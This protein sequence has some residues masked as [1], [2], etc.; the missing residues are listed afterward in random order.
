MSAPLP[1]RTPEL[2]RELPLV[3]RRAD[4]E[5]LHRLFGHESRVQPMVLVTGE[6]GVGKSRVT[7]AVEQE[8]RHRG[9]T[10]ASGRAY[11]VET[12][13]PYSL[14]S[15]AFLPILRSYDDATLTVLTRGTSGDL[16]QLFPAL[17]S[18]DDTLEDWDPAESKTRLF[19]SFTEFV[20]R[21]AERT[22]VLIVAEDLH[23]ADASSLSLLHFVARQ[24]QGEPIRVLATVSSG[25]GKD[26]ESLRGFERSLS[27]LDLLARH[28]LPPLSLDAVEELLAAVFQVGG[29]PLHEFAAPLY[30]WTHGNPYFL[31]ETLKTL[32]RTG[33]LHHRDGTWLGWEARNLDLP[34][35][36]RDALLLRL[37]S[38]SHAARAVADLVAVSGG[39]A[40]VRLLSHVGDLAQEALMNAVEEL[41]TQAVVV[42]REE[43]RDVVL[44]LRHPMLRETVYR[45]LGPS[46]RQLLH[47]RL[48][49]GL[50]ALH[51]AADAPVDQLAYHFTRAGASG[52][53]ARA[54]RYLAEAGRSALRRHADQEAVAYLETALEWY[55]EA[56]EAAPGAGRAELPGRGA[57]Q[58][59]LARGLARLGRYADGAVLWEHLLAVARRDEDAEGSAEALHHLGLLAYWSARQE[60]SLAYY[61]RALEAIAERGLQALEARILLAAGVAL[62]ELG[63]AQEARGRIEASLELARSLAD[64]TLLGR[65]HRALALLFTWIGE[66]EAARRHGWQAVEIADRAG[67]AYV[68]FWG[69]WALAS[70]EG[71]TGNTPEMTRLTTQASQVADEL[72]SPVLRLWTAELEI[73]YLLAVGDW[74]GA[75]ALGE[76]AISLSTS[77]SQTSLLPRFLVWTS[78]IYLGRGDLERGRELA[79]RAWSLAGLDVDGRRGDLHVAVSAHIGRTTCLL[80]EGRYA[81]AAEVGRA[82]L[83]LA[84]SAGYVFWSL[85]LLLPIV[86]EALLRDRDL[87]GAKAIARR[88]HDADARIGHPLAAAWADACDAL[89][90]WISGD[91]VGGLGLLE[92]AARALEGIPLTYD[93]ARIRRQLA[94][95]L[96]EVGR[97]EDALAQLRGVHETFGAL[98]AL[99]ELNRTRDMFRELASRPPNL[100]RPRGSAELTAREW[101][102]AIRV[103]DRLSN[104]AIAKDLGIAQRTVTTHL[105]NIYRKLGIGSRGELVDLVREARL[106]GRPTHPST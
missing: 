40:P 38:L 74:D 84:D 106:P 100:V 19:W 56:G 46:R 54:T 36:V 68:R 22:P 33:R 48:A 88:L 77:L 9:W 3:G 6:P 10:V 79:D 27:S 66:A 25:Y 21:L 55:P 103:A 59:D 98:G 52:Q 12:G 2:P 70:L 29:S 41:S 26:L 53:D 44:E 92:G 42:E 83:R 95:R 75:L 8:A 71:L 76:R 61:D 30:E 93:A 64:P 37:E 5:R 96:A 11:P 85:S 15:D 51:S 28:P 90:L 86:A 78:E 39:R 89:V 32:V 81:E 4:L 97:R 65:G 13:M 101:D 58:R 91:V 17:G 47:R 23:W 45:H 20:K 87:E 73:Q 50:E 63:R 99:P 35:S 102:V 14:L 62:Q 80:A 16:R 69:R 49:E 94:G 67:D 18:A 24:L 105:G 31:E 104:K 43:G 82:G 7:A 72:H 1:A 34:G 57:L 60:D